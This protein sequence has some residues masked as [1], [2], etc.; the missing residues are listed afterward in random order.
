VPDPRANDPVVEGR[1][2][3]LSLAGEVTIP[4]TRFHLRGTHWT[5]DPRMGSDFTYRRT[6]L[7]AAGDVSLG[8]HLAL[9]PRA[10]Y[11]RL[12]GEVL[13][14][15]AFYFGGAHDLR[16]LD[17]YSVSGSG[18]AF[19]RTD[20]VLVDDLGPLLHLPLPAWMPLQLGA[21]AGSGAIFGSDAATGTAL[22]SRRDWP[23]RSEWMSEAG[24]SL[25]WRAGIPD[26]LSALR[27][28]YALPIG[29]DERSAGFMISFSHP[30]GD[31]HRD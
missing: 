20:L 25:A 23:R 17:P 22:P 19:A 26:P 31:L 9:V 3:E 18:L 8:T 28:E 30:L 15:D 14:Q 24:V 1:A 11:G 21:F 10:S 2:R 6:S 7:L 4:G 13:P 29:A 12:R 27:F 5:S 16:T